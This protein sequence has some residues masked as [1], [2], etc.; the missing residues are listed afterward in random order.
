L[1]NASQQGVKA[2]SFSALE[3]LL[4]MNVFDS[5]LKMQNLMW[6]LLSKIDPRLISGAEIIFAML[7]IRWC[8]RL[9]EEQ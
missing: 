3:R 5:M 2:R 9:K 8:E 4:K 7:Q 6:L 1:I